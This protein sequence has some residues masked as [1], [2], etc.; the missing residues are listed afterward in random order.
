MRNNR[1]VLAWLEAGYGVQWITV[2]IGGLV[3]FFLLWQYGWSPIQQKTYWLTQQE[4]QQ[5][6]QYQQRL[7]ALHALPAFFQLE[8][9]EEQLREQILT[10]AG[11]HFSLPAL[12][13]ASGGR[14][15]QWQPEEKGGELALILGWGQISDLLDYLQQ[16]KPTLSLPTFVLQGTPPQLHLRMQLHHEK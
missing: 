8:R 14:L 10:D 9:Q 6:H 16:V 13:S 4:Q 2:G 11:A 7:Q 12:L 15:E 1:W 3:L 5:Y